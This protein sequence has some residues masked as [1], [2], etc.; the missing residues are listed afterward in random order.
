MFRVVLTEIAERDISEIDDFV[1]AQSGS[2]ELADRLV[3]TLEKTITSLADLPYRFPAVR[4]I[5]NP[6][7]R[8]TFVGAFNIFFHVDEEKKEVAILR[9]MRCSQDNPFL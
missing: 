4:S 6:C 8:Y 5:K 7:I 1:L 2:V 3:N 9:V